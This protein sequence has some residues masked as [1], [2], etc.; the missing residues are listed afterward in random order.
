[1]KPILQFLAWSIAAGFVSARAAE[2][3][4][5]EG[6]KVTI[7]YGLGAGTPPFTQQWFK[8][9]QPIPGATALELIIPSAKA[10]DAGN[11]RVRVANK[12]GETTSDTAGISIVV[13]PAQAVTKIASETV[14]AVP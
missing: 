12:A 1:M 11:Y 14:P 5:N 7:T 10:A 3:T 8:D 2:A 4:V 6:A 9:G 13:R